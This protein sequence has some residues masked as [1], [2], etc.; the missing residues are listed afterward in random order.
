MEHHFSLDQFFSLC[1]IYNHKQSIMA[2]V[3]TSNDT[4]PRSKKKHTLSM[5]NLYTNIKKQKQLQ[6]VVV[7]VVVALIGIHF[8]AS[9]HA[10]SPYVSVEAESGTLSGNASVQSDA[11]ASG[12]SDVLFGGSSTSS[13]NYFT[14]YYKQ[15]SNGPDPSGSPDYYPIGVWYGNS[16]SENGGVPDPTGYLALG[17]NTTMKDYSNDGSKYASEGWNTWQGPPGSG[18]FQLSAPYCHVHIRRG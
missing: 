4:N 14:S 5:K 9:S 13:T 18:S 11:T 1:Y 10:A 3:P 2:H 12:G 8:I 17:I 6:R 15:W 16:D 7:V